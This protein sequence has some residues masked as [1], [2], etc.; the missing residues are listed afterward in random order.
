MKSNQIQPQDIQI[1]KN[2]LFDFKAEVINFNESNEEINSKEP[3]K[4]NKYEEI[5]E[6]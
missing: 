5:F 2:S 4:K 6:T 1:A 3:K